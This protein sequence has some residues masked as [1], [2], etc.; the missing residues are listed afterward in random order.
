MTKKEINSRETERR[1]KWFGPREKPNT[2]VRFKD[3]NERDKLNQ[4]EH[5]ELEHEDGD[6]NANLDGSPINEGP[7][8]DEVVEEVST[9]LRRSTRT[10]VPIKRLLNEQTLYQEAI[11][12][13]QNGN[14][15]KFSKQIIQE[16]HEQRVNVGYYERTSSNISSYK[17][18]R[19]RVAQHNA[20]SLNILK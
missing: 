12:P 9:E 18:K 13:R 20:M 2:K 19:S 4:D 11:G 17:S 1:R 16:G 5:K 7:I 8:D 10:K 3:D 6:E 15:L 14:C